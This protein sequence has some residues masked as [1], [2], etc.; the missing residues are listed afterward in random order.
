[1]KT[2]SPAFPLARTVVTGVAL[3]LY[4][5]PPVIPKSCEVEAE[6]VPEPPEV[7]TAV[8]LADEAGLEADVAVAEALL[9][10]CLRSRAMRGDKEGRKR[11]WMGVGNNFDDVLG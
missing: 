8:P 6:A 4:P 5:G 9:A 3:A 10:C 7:T 2:I 1:M 11:K